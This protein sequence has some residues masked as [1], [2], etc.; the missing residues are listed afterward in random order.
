MSDLHLVVG[1]KNYSSWS[2][3]PWL[4]ISVAGLPFRETVIQLDVPDTA[5]KIRAHSRAGKVP[6]LHHGD[7]TVWES[8]AIIEYLAETFP[9]RGLWPKSREARAVAR[10]AAAEMHAG[11]AALRNACPMNLRRPR[12]KIAMDD[13]VKRDIASIQDLWRDCRSRFGNGGPFLFGAF[14]GADAMFAPVATRFETYDIAVDPDTR[15]YMDAIL[16]LPAFQAWR[17]A[18]LKEPW[19]I[20][21]DEVD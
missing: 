3:R 5:A 6:V 10:S 7:V 21:A 15:A 17:E 14:C 12:R 8:L 16:S 2:L 18:G 9:D 11:F 1:N 13:A 20:A 19:T 4:A